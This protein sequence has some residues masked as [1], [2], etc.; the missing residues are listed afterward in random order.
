LEYHSSRLLQR[1]YTLK[2]NLWLFRERSKMTWLSRGKVMFLWRQ[3]KSIRSKKRDDGGGVVK[4]CTIL[5]NVI[6]GRPLQIFTHLN[7]WVKIIRASINE[8]NF[9][10]VYLL[11]NME[12]PLYRLSN[13]HFHLKF[14]HQ[15]WITLLG[16]QIHFCFLFSWLKKLWV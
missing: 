14:S 11:S 8:I 1:C 6:Y 3:N 15:I 10:G 5:R 16:A 7:R 9:R 12:I 13:Q 4:K 2:P